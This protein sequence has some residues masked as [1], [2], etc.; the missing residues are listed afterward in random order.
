[1]H[2]PKAGLELHDLGLFRVVASGQHVA[3]DARARE[4]RRQGAHV[5][6]H[7]PAIARAWLGERGGVNA[8]D[9]KATYGHAGSILPVRLG[10]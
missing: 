3:I 5:D 7:P 4:R 9:R 2:D 8:E 1:M 6:V 10:T